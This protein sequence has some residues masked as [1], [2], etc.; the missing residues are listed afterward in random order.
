L[1]RQ[2]TLIGTALRLLTDDEAN[3]KALKTS[4]GTL[5]RVLHE[6]N[7]STISKDKPEA[8]LYFYED[9][10]EV[11]DKEL[12]KQTGSY[13]TPPEV[14][15]A[16]VRLVDEALRGPVFN[17]P[18]GLASADVMIADPAVGTG[19]FLLGV[20]RKIAANVSD[21]QGEGSVAG[22]IRS[23]ATRLFGFEL[24]FGP[25]AVAQLRLLAEMQSLVV[26]GKG[27]PQ[28][29]IPP[30]NLYV[31]DTLSNPF[32]E[33]EQLPSIVEAV[34]KSRRDANKVKRG[35][36]ITVVI[37]NP[38]YKNHAGG[39][40]S[41]VENGSDGRDAPLDWW[42]PPADWGVGAHTHH[43]KNL[44]VYF[45]R[46]AALKVFGSGWHSATGESEI[47]RQGVVCFITAAGFLNGPAFPK[48]R[49][50]LRRS[51][52]DI[53]VIDCSP[54]GH[55][56]EVPTRIFQGVMQPVCI[57]LA[58]S[59]TNKDPNKPARL[60]FMALPEG[61]RQIKF[62]ALSFL[63]LTKSNWIEGPKGW[64][65]PFLPKHGSLWSS[66]PQLQSLFVWAGSGVTPHRTWPISPDVQTLEGRWNALRAEKDLIKKEALFHRD[67]DRNVT[68]VVNVNLGTHRTRPVSV[69]ED[70]ATVVPPVRY[71]FRSF[72]RQ[73]IIPDNR[74]LSMQRPKL[75]ASQSDRQIYLTGLNSSSPKNGPAITLTHLITDLDHFHG[76]GGRVYPLWANAAANHSNVRSELLGFMTESYGTEVHAEDVVAYITAVM[77]HSDFTIR[78]AKDLKR[79][80]L[81][82]PLTADA[83]L[84]AEAVELGHEVVWLHCYGE[85]F[86]DEEKGR[87]FGPP[88]LPKDIA[89]TIPKGGAIPPAPE[90]LPDTMTYDAAKKRLHVGAGY[91][92]NVTPEIWNYEISGKQ[93]V[94]QWF[95]YRRRDRTRPQIGEKRPPSPLDKIQPDGWLSEYT[96]DLLD[97]LNVLGR[98]IALEPRQADLL[99]RICDGPLISIADLQEAVIVEK[100]ETAEEEAED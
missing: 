18:T 20:L 89:P 13:Y 64:R 85:R 83:K 92:D 86:V 19:T 73:W 76:R 98:V 22:A 77:S 61:K 62:D 7:W 24:Q 28:T 41:W 55:Q 91:I 40:G 2:N 44:Y 51:C 15:D 70:G 82:V 78:F 96:T 38:P 43:L 72:D 100:A 99:T 71:A 30:V 33:E 75:W 31:T 17:R 50:D 14:V 48:M 36:P 69:A 63:S 67:R 52:S 90:A 4:L 10:L 25:F 47:K 87:P 80:G 27:K 68:R 16:M 12:K 37:G 8:W 5:A 21:D 79:P 42:T 34:A 6:V 11:Y 3:Q 29:D 39:L 94:W 49:E 88:R 32:V 74:V 93:V 84:F 56:P 46:W 9:F 60:H 1:R 35:R 57:V 54:E 59:A 23:A 26:D 65:E 97:L 58:A 95:S 45:W 66:F 53:W 81:R